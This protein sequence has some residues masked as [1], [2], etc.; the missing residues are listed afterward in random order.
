[1]FLCYNYHVRK[2]YFFALLIFFFVQTICFAQVYTVTSCSS[3]TTNVG[4]L[5]WAVQNANQPGD[6]IQFN[7][8]LSVNGVS[9]STGE[10]YP[11]LVSDS[12]GGKWF[13]IILKAPLQIR[14]SGISINGRSQS[15]SVASNLGKPNIEIRG[16]HE[17]TNWF[18][19]EYSG[20]FLDGI[21]DCIVEGL[22]LNGFRYAID[23]E[24]N[25]NNNLIKDCF[26]GLSASG[27][28][29]YPNLG[30]ILIYFS[31][32]NRIGDGT[33][34]GRNII[35]GNDDQGIDIRWFSSNNQVLGN[36]I[37]TNYAGTNSLGNFYNG[38][39]I[40]SDSSN[41]KIGNATT[42]GRNVI[43]G[44][45]YGITFDSSTNEALGN[46][47]GTDYLG[48]SLIGNTSEGI[49]LNSY[50]NK[51]GNGT[52][53]GK[54]IICGNSPGISLNGLNNKASGN[55]IGVDVT[56]IQSIPNNYGVEVY[57][58]SCFVGDATALFSNVI[59]GNKNSGIRVLGSN[60]EIVGNYIGTD[61][62]GTLI[63]PN[64]NG[65]EF[66]ADAK[67]N[68]IGNSEN[69]A[70]NVIANNSVYGITAANFNISNNKISENSIYNNIEKGISLSNGA[71]NG[72]VPPTI[73][74]VD[75]NAPQG[76]LKVEGTSVAN[77][78]IEI[79]KAEQSQG[80]TFLGSGNASVSG[81]FSILIDGV[82]T[83]SDYIV[84][85]QT[86]INDNT[87]EFT[88]ASGVVVSQN[89]IYGPDAMI[90]TKEGV[91]L[92]EGVIESQ[93]SVQIKTL[94]VATNET[95]VYY[96]KFKN[97]GNVSDTLTIKGDTLS[98][99][100]EVSYY[101]SLSGGTNIT[102]SVVGAGY[103]VTLPAN[104]TFDA[105]LEI[106]YVKNHVNL[107]ELSTQEIKISAISQNDPTKSDAVSSI[108]TFVPLGEIIYRPDLMVASVEGV[109]VGEGIFETLPSSQDVYLSL[110]MGEKGVFYFRAKNAGTLRDTLNIYAQDPGSDFTIT[111]YDT[112]TGGN[113]ITESVTWTGYNFDLSPNE[114]KDFRVEVIYNKNIVSANGNIRL[115][116]S[117]LG[118]NAK[119]DV[120]LLNVFYTQVP[121]PAVV[122]NTYFVLN[123]SSDETREGSLPWAVKNATKEGSSI[124][125]NIQ[126]AGVGV[127]SGNASP[128]FVQ[129]GS[130]G[131]F[132]IVVNSS[133]EI[134]SNFIDIDA[135][136]QTWEAG[137]GGNHPKIE[138][139]AGKNDISGFII[140]KKQYCTIEGF[141]IV[142]FNGTGKAGVGIKGGNYNNIKNCY[143]G[144][145]PDGSTANPNYYGILLESNSFYNLI[146][147][148]DGKSGNVISGNKNVGIFMLSSTGNIILGNYIG[149]DPAG[150]NKLSN[151]NYGL[152]LNFAHNTKI[153][154]KT[155]NGR[156]IISGNSF[157]GVYLNSSNSCEVFGNFIGVDKSGALPLANAQHAVNFYASKY[158][159]IGDGTSDGKN[160]ISSNGFSGIKIRY[161]SGSNEIYG[162]N[163]GVDAGGTLDL[164][165]GVYG[166]EILQGSS[167][168]KIGKGN[169]IAYNGSSFYPAGVNVD[170]MTGSGYGLSQKNTISQN[171]IF[172][173]YGEGIALVNYG[174]NGI[175]APV[176]NNALLDGGLLTVSGTSA[177]NS[178][179]EIFKANQGQGEIYLLK[180]PSDNNGNWI[181]I[182]ESSLSTQDSLVANQTDVFGNTSE[183]STSQIIT[184]PEKYYQPDMMIATLEGG[185]VGEGVIENIPNAQVVASSVASNETAV[186]KFKSLNHGNENDTF[187]ITGESVNGSF[188]VVYY[189]AVLESG[190]DIT[191]QVVGSGYLLDLTALSSTEGRFEVNY[192]GNTLAT[193]EI[194]M[195]LISSNDPTKKDTVKSKTTFIPLPS[196]PLPV[197]QPDLMIGT[198]EGGA[199]Y[200]EEGFYES[201]T[202]AERQIKTLTLASNEVAV[203]YFKVKNGGDIVDDIELACAFG[204]DNLNISYF[205]FEA[206]GVLIDI[207][208][209]IATSGGYDRTL[210]AGEY[211]EGKALIAYT[212]NELLTAEVNMTA[213]SLKQFDRK[214]VIKMETTFIPL[215]PPPPPPPPSVYQPDMMI[216]TLEGGYV[217]EGIYENVPS[218]QVKTM[219]LASNEVGVYRLKSLNAG[220]AADT[221]ILTGEVGAGNYT[222]TYYDSVNGVGDITS[223]VGG[224]GYLI[225]LSA[226]GSVEGRIE[227]V[228][229][230]NTLATQ[231]ITAT[232]I[233][234]ND[235]TKKDSVKVMTTFIP[236][237]PPP[238]P[239]P[240]VYQP[241][242]MIATL[243]GGYVGEGIYE[244]VPLSQIIATE[245]LTNETASLY[246]KVSNAS[247]TND[248]IIINGDSL[249]GSFVISYYDLNSGG[250]D[251]TQDITG[252]GYILPLLPGISRE[253][254][255]DVFYK[256]EKSA[257][258]EV[259]IDAVSV[260]DIQKKDKAKLV[261]GFIPITGTTSTGAGTQ[262]S[263]STSHAT[264][265]FTATDLKIPG[266]HITIPAAS[267][268]VDANVS[269]SIFAEK[270]GNLPQGFDLLSKVFGITS[271]INEFEVP[272]IV[273]IPLDRILNDPVRVYY[274]TGS[275]WSQSGIKIVE[276]NTTSLVFTTTHFTPFAAMGAVVSSSSI[277]GPNPYNPNNGSAR[278]YYWL[279]DEKDT[280]IFII[281]L[282]GNIVWKKTFIAGQNGAQKQGNNVEFD[283]KDSWGN[284]LAEGVYLYKIIQD[285]IVV[286]GGK[287]SVIK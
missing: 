65:I 32:N 98:S 254:R 116:L 190:R 21:S 66:F 48:T 69:G 47:I 88:P 270:P 60:N 199:D 49:A 183:F 238:P 90:A 273:T 15:T 212:G 123:C 142:G 55:F 176:I 231:E 143:I 205:V 43:S 257:T 57:G 156:N 79:F 54:N 46:F 160:V 134:Q 89:I 1:M 100:Y 286:T 277:F 195:T 253:V 128:G 71:N 274:W 245:V 24:N 236:V 13:R 73:S 256:G 68:K 4:S 252:N 127:S 58:G 217:G 172:S 93:P 243:E 36:Y 154:N 12:S 140:N 221:L 132:R 170:G 214:D 255:V 198:L 130:D 144:L 275:G 260:S 197:Y 155:V 9:S 163:I 180:W 117:S 29:A 14:S 213:S 108:T 75:Y 51:V 147:G 237:P 222:V 115:T 53:A 246:F 169:I 81:S 30:G 168:N 283:G 267:T 96:L 158:N 28:S 7:L 162:N 109:Y 247:D 204:I 138:V 17:G 266:M 136:T 37:G 77:S 87:S 188:N 23:I 45:R 150:A 201:G 285:G 27:E 129:N 20:L 111:Y 241:D 5:P 206:G 59:S 131:W 196:P 229:K 182:F 173:N 226:L 95:A 244:N 179:V 107:G 194:T 62:S 287:I 8:A 72:I 135:S 11:G 186:Y 264:Q 280:T 262:P 218:L 113:D 67:Y 165:N 211:Y 124:L 70:G 261:F 18:D 39:L 10:A 219:S 105:R 31:S 91:Y 61:L 83:S 233:S 122:D 225:N 216:A 193:Q 126:L 235:P 149:T 249:S 44:N 258:S 265:E 148:M 103:S 34:T 50:D 227:I 230:G 200:F 284:T 192:T 175:S 181:A 145:L 101:N 220:D 52:N 104:E 151:G 187:I 102:S 42:G 279:S 248:N 3:E 114:Y 152:S 80:K 223:Q 259:L 153:G 84:A 191:A 26:I 177:P 166:V 251:I 92:G 167:F 234:S 120:G 278:I 164:G 64:N 269:V 203:Y 121:V 210:E 22:V 25:S 19:G 207:T 6:I 228:N 240:S 276:F 161:N 281:N 86:D 99:D 189:D 74:L 97:A 263:P 16:I 56:G 272:V 41:N 139:V 40:L 76:K 119:K 185:Y 184:I 94:S 282:V 178:V 242:M 110:Y 33:A 2:L 224:S 133:L 118:D 141:S 112:A 125:F 171:S 146:G 106:K 159:K 157:G 137:S 85:T 239:P 232:L 82:F 35:S 38:V 202:F 209:D 271:S 208:P 215:V 63:L 268:T 174:N 250:I 78:L